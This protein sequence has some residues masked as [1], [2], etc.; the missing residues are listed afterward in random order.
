[1]PVRSLRTDAA[2]AARRY[3]YGAANK[4]WVCCALC[5]REAFEPLASIDRYDMGLATVGCRAC[6]LVQ[7]NPRLTAA[8]LD[9]FYRLHYRAYYQGV[10]EPSQAYV[11]QMHKEARLDATVR[12]LAEGGALASGKA[13]LDVGC[14]EGTF[15]AA[16]RRGGFTGRL[17]G[18]E[19][20][21]AFRAY[22]AATHGAE[23]VADEAGLPPGWR[24]AI[25]LATMTHVLEHVA[26]PVATLA[27]LRGFLAEDGLLY[28]DVPDVA[29]Y[30]TVNDLHI[31]HIV[32]FGEATLR[33][34]LAAAGFHVLRLEAHRPAHHPKSVR[35]LARPR[36]PGDARS[37]AD[38]AV[39]DV[40][41]GWPQLRRIERK[42]HRR[43]LKRVLRNALAPSRLL[44]ALRRRLG[45]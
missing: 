33:A 29:E 31:A 14:S 28:V 45:A 42:R 15:F 35:A 37:A 2:P 25:G 38:A 22:A 30:G 41:A 36:A 11:R 1:M 24:G 27:R 19:P 8:E 21:P 13:V 6:G 5:G 34:T 7:T 10:D 3:D 40:R 20:N 12:F 23:T 4:E 43:A 26:D 44:Q 9:A 16:L 32:H 17:L 18:V 39:G